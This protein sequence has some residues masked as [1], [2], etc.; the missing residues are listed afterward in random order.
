M[1]EPQV[2][3]PLKDLGARIDKASG[4]RIGGRRSGD[5]RGAQG[6]ALS[7]GMRAGLE[8][9]VGVVVGVVVG[10]F[11]DRYFGIKLWG[12]IGGFFLGVAAGM[13]NV[14][15]TVTGIGMAAGYRQNRPGQPPA[16]GD[17]WDED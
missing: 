8:L 17:D 9:V 11:I 12:V 15:R 5:D 7:I 16:S 3:D 1:D 2:P 13:V 6:A 10:S 14:Y 4:N